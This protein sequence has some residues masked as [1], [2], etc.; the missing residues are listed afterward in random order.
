[1]EFGRQSRLV[2]TVVLALGA[3]AAQSAAQTPQQQTVP[4]APAPQTLP[5]LSPLSAVA[6]AIPQQPAPATDDQSVPSNLGSALPP[7][8]AHPDDGPPPEAF[9]ANAFKLAAINVQFVQLP[10]TVK[11]SK[12]HLIPGITWRDVRVYEDGVREPLRF[13]TTDPFPL[14]VAIVIDQ[15]VTYDT[16]EKINDSLSALQAAFT[17]YDEVAL[18]TYNNGASQKTEFTAAQSARLTALLERT[19]GRGRDPV[20]GM[21]SPLENNVV[22]NNGVPDPNVGARGSAQGGIAISQ[23]KEFHT[24][25][26]AIFLAAKTDAAAGPGRRRIIFVISDG[27]E[28]GSK[29]KEKDLIKYLERNKIEV[30]ATLVGNISIPGTGFL[31]RIH[32]PLTMRDNVLPRIASVTGGEVDPEF[33]PKGIEASFARITEEVRTQYTAG[34]YTHAS[35][36]D[37]RFRRTEVKIMRPGLTVIAKEGY[38]PTASDSRPQSPANTPA[39]TAP[40]Q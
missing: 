9:S 40:L 32:L 6:P 19:K 38:Y 25:L 26:D 20:M 12:N 2:A 1:M 17:P 21:A 22:I 31:D 4:N 18:F 36:F 37:E 23:P 14:S 28:Y 30:Y 29:I 15:S 24:L 35:P 8:E 7:A 34:Y 13:F 16:M 27:K 33:R 5:R 10:F 39:P 3:I 11:D